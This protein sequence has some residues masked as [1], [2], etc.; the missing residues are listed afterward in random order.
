MTAYPAGLAACIECGTLTRR[1]DLAIGD[2][3]CSKCGDTSEPDPNPEP[4]PRIKRVFVC[5]R[6]NR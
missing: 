3:Q 5:R 2:P 6:K 1:R 4:R